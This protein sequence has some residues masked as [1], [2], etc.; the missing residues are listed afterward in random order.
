LKKEEEKNKEADDAKLLTHLKTE[1]EL[2]K[3]LANAQVNFNQVVN[4]VDKENADEARYQISLKALQALAVAE[5]KYGKD[6]VDGV[7]K[8]NTEIETLQSEHAL[9]MAEE[10]KK[11]T[12]D[13]DKNLGEMRKLV[14]ERGGVD[15]V[16]PKNMQQLLQF[17]AA[18]KELG[19]VLDTD[20]AQ[21]ITL[22][23]KTLQDYA[24]AGGKDVYVI[25]QL[26]EALA[27]LEKQY[28]DFPSREKALRSELEFAKAH[29]QSTVEIEREIKALSDEEK[30]L[31]VLPGLLDR[32]KSAM[33]ELSQTGREAASTLEMAFSQAM[34]GMLTHQEHFGT[35]MEKAVFKMLASM[36]Q[37]WAAYY[38][39]L[40]IGNAFTPG[41]QAAAAGEFAAATALEALAGTL[42]ALG[43]RGGAGGSGGSNVNGGGSGGNNFAYGSSV[44]NTGSQAGSG[45]SNI[46][47][48]G[49]ADGGLV[50]GPTL[51]MIGEG[52][53]R[54][55]A[56]PLDNP[57]AMATIGKAVSDAMAKNGG[58]RG[59]INVHVHGHVIG[60]SDVAHL[61]AQISKRV[62]NG[63]AH[64]NSSSTFKVTKRG[65]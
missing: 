48:Q 32:T 53:G 6:S 22:A 15:I 24:D 60:A 28:A 62:A 47:V 57:D 37:Q 3:Q 56:I 29:H 12:T 13:L 11:Q 52:G 18:A 21:K 2:K 8:I 61:C 19:V 64:L 42:N 54:E 35:A 7:R 51:A 27:K 1:I 58:G 45:R 25:N 17:R 16:L 31:G 63:Q 23:K 39:A 65:A 10:L 46:G 50:S 14:V 40:A 44:S 55:A 33:D 59:G 5:A 41:M 30:K 26:K 36:A 38:L 9:R 49:F 34:T 43:G 4:G 20:L